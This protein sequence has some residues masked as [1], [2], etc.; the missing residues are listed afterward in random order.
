MVPIRDIFTLF[1]C[2]RV[3]GP[4]EK[5]FSHEMCR[6]RCVSVIH[7][8]VGC[9]RYSLRAPEYYSSARLSVPRASERSQPT[10][11]S[12]VLPSSFSGPPFPRRWPLLTSATREEGV[13]DE[14]ITGCSASLLFATD[15]NVRA[16]LRRR[17]LDFD[18]S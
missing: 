17:H 11:R 5:E 7:D 2:T 13:N 8:R 6:V 15:P 16:Y 1:D 9:S 12:R 14:I 18:D 4:N 10:R 3:T